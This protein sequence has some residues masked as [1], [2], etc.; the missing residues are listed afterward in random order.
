MPVNV[1][2]I[3]FCQIP[4]HVFDE[5]ATASFNSSDTLTAWGD[6]DEG[7]ESAT[8]IAGIWNNN[9]GEANIL[10]IQLPEK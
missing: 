5:T 7:T 9:V 6:E 4:D 3:I 2:R 1:N 10:T 8:E